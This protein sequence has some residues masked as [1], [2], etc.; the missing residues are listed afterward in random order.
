MH[1][2]DLERSRSTALFTSSEVCIVRYGT[3]FLISGQTVR[4]GPSQWKGVWHRFEALLS[5]SLMVWNESAELQRV[6]E[7][8]QRKS[9]YVIVFCSCTASLN[10]SAFII[11]QNPRSEI[12]LT[13]RTTLVWLDRDV[14]GFWICFR[15]SSLAELKHGAGESNW[16]HLFT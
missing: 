8:R 4:D 5:A 2:R 3:Y 15:P 13:C 14:K 7:W 10:L 9:V 6:G 11:H 1:N 16:R 12:N